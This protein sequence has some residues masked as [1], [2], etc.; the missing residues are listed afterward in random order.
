MAKKEAEG[1][2]NKKV[3][4]IA[5]VAVLIIAIGA[6]A[7][8]FFLTQNSGEKEEEIFFYSPGEAFITNLQGSNS[9]LK[10]TVTVAYNNEKALTDLEENNSVV[11]NA[12]VFVLRNKTKEQMQAADIE[13]TLSNEICQ[14]LNSELG[15]DYI[16]KIYF[17]DLV[18]QG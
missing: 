16:V 6:G 17:S 9:L 8:V 2:S 18:V 3:I 12:I 13:T 1:G 7:A 11:R 14:R 4:I 5:I 10:T 15:V